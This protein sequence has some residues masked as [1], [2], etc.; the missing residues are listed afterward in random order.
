MTQ[1]IGKIRFDQTIKPLDPNQVHQLTLSS[2]RTMPAAAFGTFHSDWAQEYMEDATVEA[3]RLGWRH[4]DTAR[5]YENEEVAGEAIRRA[6]KEGYIASA[7]DLFIT[8]KLWNG[9]MAPADVAPAC[10]TTLQALGVEKLDLYVN[11]WPWPNVHAP[12]CEGDHRNPDAVP[13]I[14]DQF[15][16]TWS[17][18]C[19]LKKSGKVIDIGT[20]NH[21]EATMKLLL[22]D[23]TVEER[24]V[25]NQMEMHPLFQQTELR[26]Y[27]ES[28]EIVCSGYMAVG[29]PHR[30]GRDTFKEHRA[31]LEDPTI[32]EMADELGV[33]PGSVALSW[34]IQREN[35]SG[36]FVVM[37]TQSQRIRDNLSAAVEDL[38]SEEQLLRISGDGTPEN[39][40]I[41]ANN[42][43][44]WGQV[45]LWPEADGDWRILWDD[46]QVF[47]TQEGYQRFKASW[48]A[49]HQVQLETTY[50]G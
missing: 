4:I 42:R 21:T 10:E 19:K 37:S 40:G 36:G 33:S 30:P 11:H 24:P 50:R 2:G 7:N 49:H 38:L 28:E 20:S 34:A 1:K 17:E 13:Y 46:S 15:M 26:R 48:E 44:I 8:G 25:Y 47:L 16:E 23:V 32:L 29:S 31:D 14:H 43:L 12:G 18:I 6:I 39:P 27:F 45:F 35:K 41:D 3:I 22:R 9:H 5:A